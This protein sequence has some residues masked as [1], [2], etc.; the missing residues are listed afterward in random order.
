MMQIEWAANTCTE[1]PAR[2]EETPARSMGLPVRVGLALRRT[3]VVAKIRKS[4]MGASGRMRH[5]M[6]ENDGDIRHIY[7]FFVALD[8][9]P[10]FAK[11]GWGL[12]AT[13]FE[14]K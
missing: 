10:K 14:V 11:V 2:G 1:N 9:Q 6:R 13:K 4:G 8:S 12:Y 3:G 7:L 5:K